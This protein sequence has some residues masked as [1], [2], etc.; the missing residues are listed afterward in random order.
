MMMMIMMGALVETYR[1]Q[2]KTTPNNTKTSLRRL[3]RVTGSLA[4]MF[5][6]LLIQYDAGNCIKGYF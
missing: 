4:I 3:N 2:A 1:V 6:Q 5:A